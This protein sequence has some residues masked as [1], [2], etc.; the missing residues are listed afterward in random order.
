MP[1]VTLLKEGRSITVEIPQDDVKD[2]KFICYDISPEPESAEWQ[3]ALAIANRI[4]SGYYG[5][6]LTGAVVRSVENHIVL[7]L[8]DWSS[9]SKY[10]ALRYNSKSG[11]EK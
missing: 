11:F 6:P 7:N 10:Y 4:F 3:K 2:L 1:Y 8:M 5:L 9:F